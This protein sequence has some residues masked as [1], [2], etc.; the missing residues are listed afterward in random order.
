MVAN[1]YVAFTMKLRLRK[2][3]R[4]RSCSI[5]QRLNSN[6]G[7]LAPDSVFMISLSH[8]A[9]F[10]TVSH[11]HTNVRSSKVHAWRVRNAPSRAKKK[12]VCSSGSR[13]PAG[14]KNLPGPVFVL[15]NRWGRADEES[16]R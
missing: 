7:R 15:M 6:M 10:H 2:G 13:S 3:N 12:S 8:V 5:Q 4:P 16:H 9:S 14:S 1:T 11:A